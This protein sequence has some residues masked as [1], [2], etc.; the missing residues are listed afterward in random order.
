MNEGEVQKVCVASF[1][2][3]FNESI[4]VVEVWNSTA[5]DSG[6][7]LKLN[8][9]YVKWFHKNDY[10]KVHFKIFFAPFSADFRLTSTGL[11]I[12]PNNQEDCLVVIALDDDVA[13]EGEET[14][15]LTL[16]GPDSV[17]ITNSV[18]EVT[19]ID[20]DGKMLKTGYFNTRITF[21]IIILMTVLNNVAL[22]LKNWKMY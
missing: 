12:T 18:L 6:K 20:T 5:S 14:V 16:T 3:L 17:T 1:G 2:P 8:F 9:L 15:I 10:N 22:Y 21:V 19:I 4:L 11:K 7:I 13:L